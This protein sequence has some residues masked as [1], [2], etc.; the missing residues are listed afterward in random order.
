MIFQLWVFTIVFNILLCCDRLYGAVLTL[1]SQLTIRQTMNQMRASVNVFNKSDANSFDLTLR[2]KFSNEFKEFQAIPCFR[3]K[4]TEVFSHDFDIHDNMKGTFP[5]IVEIQFHDSNLF[6]FYSLH[7]APISINSQEQTNIL[8]ADIMDVEISDQT[9][10]NVLLTPLDNS[11]KVVS[12]KM[13]VSGAFICHNDEQSFILGESQNLSYRIS[14]KN[15][16]PGTTHSAFVVLS[17]MKNNVSHTQIVPF[18][19]DV[20]PVSTFVFFEKQW[21]IWIYILSGIIWM[22][23]VSYVSIVY[24]KNRIQP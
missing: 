22:I 23:F 21:G 20:A 17:F 15:A 2:I 13:V 6:P 16:L 8:F 24:K 1:E 7:C 9:I 18:R 12:A 10:V 11:H 4:E 3:P 5:L 19:I 14:T